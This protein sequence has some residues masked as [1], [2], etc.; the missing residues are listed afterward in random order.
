M[1][2][3]PGSGRLAWRRRAATIQYSLLE[4]SV[5]RGYI[6]GCKELDT[7]V[8]HLV[9]VQFVFHLFFEASSQNCGSLFQGYSL[10]IIG[11]FFDLVGG[12]EGFSI[13]KTV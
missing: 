7:T 11:S 5:D 3:I 9:Q 2:S 4:N 1:N 6:V 13:Y 10:V 8:Q 12:G